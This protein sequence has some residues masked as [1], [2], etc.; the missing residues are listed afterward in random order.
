M[1]IKRAY[2]VSGG[3]TAY[4]QSSHQPHALFSTCIEL[5]YITLGNEF[6]IIAD[7]LSNFFIKYVQIPVGFYLND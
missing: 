4:R 3:A 5:R 1:K 2:A 7:P 6:F